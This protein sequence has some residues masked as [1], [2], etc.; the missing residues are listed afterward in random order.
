MSC[1]VLGFFHVTFSVSACPQVTKTEKRH[2]A[3]K[4]WE[5]LFAVMRFM[6][7]MSPV[8]LTTVL[9]GRRWN[10]FIFKDEKNLNSGDQITYP[11][12]RIDKWSSRA[13]KPALSLP[14]LPSVCLLHLFDA[15]LTVTAE[16]ESA[17]KARMTFLILGWS[18]VLWPP[19]KVS[20]SWFL[21]IPLIAISQ[22]DI[23]IW[24]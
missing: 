2:T 20:D 7:T 16:S 1:S 18:W 15:V 5:L 9:R 23:D 14:K 12:H 24:K 17:K 21:S 8:V 6:D 19:V 3:N 22:C 11:C 10:K 4:W 13:W